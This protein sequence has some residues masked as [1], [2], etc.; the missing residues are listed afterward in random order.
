M[1]LQIVINDLCR[2]PFFFFVLMILS[3]VARKEKEAV[4][5]V[6]VVGIMMAEHPWRSEYVDY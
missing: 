4:E 2:L 3:L 1:T 6:L 5:V